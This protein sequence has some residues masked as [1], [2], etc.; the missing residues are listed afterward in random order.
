[1]L[2]KSALFATCLCFVFSA[3]SFA[4]SKIFPGATW[5]A[6]H[7]LYPGVTIAA[8]NPPMPFPSR[9]TKEATATVSED[10]LKITV[11]LPDA[12]MVF[13]RICKDDISPLPTPNVPSGPYSK[14]LT[15][16]EVNYSDADGT[17]DSIVY[18]QPGGGVFT[19]PMHGTAPAYGIKTRAQYSIMPIGDFPEPPEDDVVEPEPDVAKKEGLEAATRALGK[20]MGLD[21]NFM[22]DYIFAGVTDSGTLQ[23]KLWLGKNFNVLTTD[24]DVTDPCD[25]RYGNMEPAE[26]LYVFNITLLG[27]A[28][29]YQYFV[30]SKLINV[31]TRKLEKKFSPDTRDATFYL[32]EEIG[33][34]Y[35]GLGVKVRAPRPKVD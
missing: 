24:R 12:T 35:R 7:V 8:N 19:G 29:G 16:W 5:Q 32:E 15:I 31:A 11:D 18:E 21:L 20:E 26:Y 3:P 9:I 30:D 4:Q 34:A 17:F 23:I 2:L 13:N 27:N 6:H 22:K 10:M 28:D 25:P 1:M 33:D 14:N